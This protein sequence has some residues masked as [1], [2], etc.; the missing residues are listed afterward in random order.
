VW[1]ETGGTFVVMQLLTLRWARRAGV[2]STLVIA[3]WVTRAGA[4]ATA[5]FPAASPAAAYVPPQPVRIHRFHVYAT[6]KQRR[7]KAVTVESLVTT[8]ESS[9]VA[10]DRGLLERRVDGVP[11]SPPDWL[12]VASVV[13]KK[14]NPK[15][16]IEVEIEAERAE[17]KVMRQ[18]KLPFANQ[19]KV[20]LQI[21]RVMSASR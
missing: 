11:G 1:T 21:D 9:P 7:Q 14:V 20:R 4:L 18:G 2:V 13:V 19:Q 5:A 6:M 17:A 15:G 16:R 3:S 12:A 8:S 10:G